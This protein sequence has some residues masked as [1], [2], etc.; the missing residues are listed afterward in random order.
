ML[1]RVFPQ[2]ELSS[3]DDQLLCPRKAI[4]HT[5]ATK[6]PL[7]VTHCFVGMKGRIWAADHKRRLGR[8]VAFSNTHV[9]MCMLQFGGHHRLEDYAQRGQEP[10]DEVML[11]G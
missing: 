1:I 3:L 6:Q 9:Y 4:K 10:R 8:S 2:V 7:S 5:S 11:W